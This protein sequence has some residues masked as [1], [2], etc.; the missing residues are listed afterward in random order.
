VI[1][2]KERRIA[3]AGRAAGAATELEAV[4]IASLFGVTVGYEDVSRHKP[5]PEGVH[6]ALERLGA[7]PEQTL[8]VGDSAADLQAGLA[9]GCWTC[10]AAWGLYPGHPGVDG[11]QPHAV[12]QEPRTV[13]GLVKAP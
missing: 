13:L 11:V 12:A 5:D 6:L 2:Q 9:A 4:G 10:H 7:Q 1:T 8:L 3:I